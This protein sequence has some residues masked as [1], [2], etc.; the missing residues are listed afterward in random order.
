MLHLTFLLLL[1]GF[2][3]LWPKL[4]EPEAVSVASLQTLEIADSRADTDGSRLDRA[5]DLSGDD[6][7]PAVSSSTQATTALLYSPVGP[8]LG[9]QPAPCTFKH[10]RAPPA[11]A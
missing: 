5:N 6:P 2:V 7:G 1:A 11:V 4:P 10:A 3:V 9:W 8:I